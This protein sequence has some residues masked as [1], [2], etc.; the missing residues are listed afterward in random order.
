MRD[1]G[2][3]WEYASIYVDD[4]I[5]AMIGP[6]AF[7]D[8]LQG[9]NIA[10]TMKGIGKP[11]YHLGTDLYRDED[12]TLCLG[13]QTYSKHLSATFESLYREQPKPVFSPLTTM[14]TQNLTTL[15]FVVPMTQR[16][17]NL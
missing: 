13:A 11:T 6:K 10:F 7:F 4:I 2:N 15:L 5:V 1:G 12:G 3:L 17:F 8:E 9:S 16:N 14:T